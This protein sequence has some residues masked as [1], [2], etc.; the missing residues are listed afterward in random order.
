MN[1]SKF[2]IFIVDAGGGDLSPYGSVADAELD[3][4][5]IDA[6]NGCYVG[7]DAE[8]RFLRLEA[9]AEKASIT[10]MEWFLA[11]RRSTQRL[12][13]EDKI[14]ITLAEEE[15][16]HT[17]ELSKALI[18]FL[19]RVGRP[20]TDPGNPQTLVESFRPLIQEVKRAPRK[21]G[22]LRI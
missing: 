8:G 5:A 15:P 12:R 20:P 19:T 9:A 7:Y 11:P 6:R 4:E 10:W 16:T 13:A 14:S 3:L 21:W 17:S 2:P 18:T 22:F 1:I